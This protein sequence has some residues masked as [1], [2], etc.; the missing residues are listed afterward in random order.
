MK[1]TFI[2]LSLLA[3]SLSALADTSGTIGTYSINP[4]PGSVETLTTLRF[5]FPDTGFMGIDDPKTEGITLT[6]EGD[7]SVVYTV[8]KCDYDMEDYAT[9]HFSLAGAE[10]EGVQA[11]GTYNLFVPEGAFSKF[12]DASKFN[13]E[14][15][16]TYIVTVGSGPSVPPVVKNPFEGAEITPASGS[17]N[18][19]LNTFSIT[20]PELTNGLTY[21]FTTDKKITLVRE[22]DTLTYEWDAIEVK[23]PDYK[24][25]TFG[26]D[27]PD[28]SDSQRL[29]FTEAGT[30]TLTVPEGIFSEYQNTENVNGALEWTFIVDPTLNFSCTVAP[31]TKTIYETLSEFTITAGS[32][33]SDIKVADSSLKATL[34]LDEKSIDLSIAAKDEKTLILSV[35]A[36]AAIGEGDWTLTIPSG[37]LQGTLTEEN[38]IVSNTEAITQVYKV[39]TPLSFEYSITPTSG[40]ELEL[41]KKVTVAFSGDGLSKASVN[42]EA[43]P[44]TISGGTLESPAALTGRVSGKSVELV[45][46][47]AIGDGTYTITVPDG[48]IYTTDTNKL[49]SDVKGFS[50][51]YTVKKP[52]VPDFSTG[53]LMINEGWFGHDNGSINFIGADGKTTY[54]AFKLQ[55]PG[56]ELGT[57]TESGSLYGDRVYAVSKQATGGPFL[58]GMEATTLKQIGA[59]DEI[60]YEGKKKPQAY[61]F[62]AVSEDKGY[63][64]T[65]V[66]IF[67][68]DLKEWKITKQI[69]A[70]WII[71]GYAFGD[72]Q[73]YGDYVYIT[74][75][76][77]GIVAINVHTDLPDHVDIST[78]A[79]LF[80]TG[81]G[82]LYTAT[83][84]EGGEFVRIDTENHEENVAFDIEEDKS[85]IQSPWGTWRMPSVAADR[86]RDIVYFVKAGNN[87]NTVSRYDF[88]TKQYTSDFIVLPGKEDGLEADQIFYGQGISVDPTT[89]YLV[90]NATEAGYGTH[91][92]QN[93]IYFYDTTT[94]QVV[95]DKTVKLDPYYWFPAMMIYPN[96]LAPEIS[97]EPIEFVAAADEQNISFEKEFNLAEITTLPVG[98]PHLMYLAATLSAGSPFTLEESDYGVYTLK[99]ETIGESTLTLTAEYQGKTTTLEVPVKV[100]RELGVADVSMQASSDIFTATGLL[101]K[102]NAT[103]EDLKNLP[104]GLYIFGGRK[105]MVK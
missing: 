64:S 4:A 16:A 30:Y 55:N 63:L 104:A 82:D 45:V 101:I 93:W 38:I 61:A 22:G 41:L 80:V 105:V 39:R 50:L 15:T 1:K 79:A 96:F 99:A 7:S 65:N 89:G 6:K 3:T 68:V 52:E 2:C 92:E 90:V 100:E 37:M 62:Q 46:T 34:S 72:M 5:T 17:K 66:G 86:D 97:M 12:R 77:E 87:A 71:D 75:Q 102:R 95:A 19:T 9:L 26:F 8:S 81:T 13:N 33:M 20:F 51:T 94:G 84:D 10:E 21:P 98:N 103:A 88:S 14:I 69:T 31:D 76:M 85:K 25:V 53:M 54:N 48:Y 29:T 58:V 36:E 24:T 73:R 28:A 74:S 83:L 56:L 42:A 40:S 78:A 49:T 23:G 60:P 27:K 57:T 91:Y 44:A 70:D 35:P 47:D 67:I 32:N 59:I 11:P 43:P 18:G